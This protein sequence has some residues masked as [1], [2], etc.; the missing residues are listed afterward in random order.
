MRQIRVVLLLGVLL[1]AFSTVS[2]QQLIPMS[3]VDMYVSSELELQGFP[4]TGGQLES[5]RQE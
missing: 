3:D 1:L 4:T 2:A 5:I